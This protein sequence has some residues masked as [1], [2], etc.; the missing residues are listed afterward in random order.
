LG[1]NS[2]QG[3]SSFTLSVMQCFVTYTVSKA[4]LNKD[5]FSAWM[6]I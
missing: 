2:G 5:S 1:L 6:S 4:L 3:N